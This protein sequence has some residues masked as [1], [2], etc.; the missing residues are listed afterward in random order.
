[1][2]RCN[3]PRP[4]VVTEYAVWGHENV[5][6]QTPSK[7]SMRYFLLADFSCKD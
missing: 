3:T 4:I 6:L 1:M 2:H 5:E 7:R